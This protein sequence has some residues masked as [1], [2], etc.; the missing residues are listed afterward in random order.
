MKPGKECL[1]FPCVVDKLYGRK[2]PVVEPVFAMWA[3]AMSINETY[4]RGAHRPPIAYK[5]A[6]SLLWMRSISLNV[7]SSSEQMGYTPCANFKD[8]FP[9]Y[10]LDL[11]G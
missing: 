4:T 10:L 11:G 6:L 8:A 7:V 2:T 9:L 5:F 3:R 1:T